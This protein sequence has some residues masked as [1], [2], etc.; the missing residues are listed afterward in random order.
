MRARYDAGDHHRKFVS[1]SEKG[2]ESRPFFFMPFDPW[3]NTCEYCAST[4]RQDLGTVADVLILA[5]CS[6]VNGSGGAPSAQ[7]A[8]KKFRKEFLSPVSG[9]H[10]PRD[11][12][13]LAFMREMPEMA[14]NRALTPD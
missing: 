12:A 10:I 5:T 1:I 9:S 4:S 13:K 8:Q 3:S 7:E 6:T 14:E 11:S 2:G